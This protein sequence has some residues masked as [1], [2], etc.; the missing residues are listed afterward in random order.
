MTSAI[1]S[2]LRHRRP[3]RTDAPGPGTLRPGFRPQQPLTRLLYPTKHSEAKEI[4]KGAVNSHHYHF[5]PGH[6]SASEQGARD[7]QSASS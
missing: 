4:V 3:R 2:P 1:K 6:R 5:A 7:L